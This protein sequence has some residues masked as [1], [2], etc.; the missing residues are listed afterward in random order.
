MKVSLKAADYGKLIAVILC[1]VFL[2]IT[3]LP[4]AAVQAFHAVREAIGREDYQMASR[5]LVEAAEVLPWRQDLWEQAGW[6]AA[7]AGDFR[8][9][10]AAFERAEAVGAL[11]VRGCVALGDEYLAQGDLPRAIRIWKRAIEQTDAPLDVFVK[12]RDAYLHAGNLAQAARVSRQ[13]L[14]T[15]PDAGPERVKTVALL[16][17]IQAA[18]EPKD[19]LAF[20]VQAVDYGAADAEHLRKLIRTIR[21]AIRENEPAYSLLESGRVL[22]EM[23][24]WRLALAAFRKATALRPD[25]ADAWAFLSEALQMVDLENGIVP[26]EHGYDAVQKA[27]ALDKNSFAA[28][29]IAANYWLRQ[30][31]PEKARK[32]LAFAGKLDSHNPAV[33][34]DMGAAWAASGDLV[35]AQK[36]YQKAVILAP[37]DPHFLRL[38]AKF[39]IRYQIRLGETA[40]P[41]AREAAL[42]SPYDPDSADTLGQVLYLLNDLHNAE[43]FYLKA[44]AL[45]PEYSPAHLHL[46]MLYL[47]QGRRELAEKQLRQAAQAGNLAVK[48]RAQRLLKAYF[49]P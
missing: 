12:M 27:L 32:L 9:A 47:V 45:Q 33:L 15:F 38:L 17:L 39:C 42:L 7:K 13:I 25:Y 46:A 18:S 48:Q 36:Y 2:R 31:K 3:P 8:Q 41:A 20:L 6:Y 11:S 10:A 29:I 23:G 34:A 21:M 16:G 19:A 28:N 14:V 1:I 49:S 43:K 44:L 30:E 5:L 37:N 24:R 35:K 4:V 40:L 22:G 26:P